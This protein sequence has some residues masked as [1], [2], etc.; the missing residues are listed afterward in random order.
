MIV[1]QQVSFDGGEWSPKLDC[2]ADL[3]KYGAACRLV[4]NFIPL[5]QG[6]LV[7]RPGMTLRGSMPGN[8]ADGRL[9]EFELRAANS[10][11]IAIGDNMMIF[12]KDG[13]PITDGGIVVTLGC[14]WNDGTLKLLRW[15]QI[16]D[17]MMFV[18]PDH[19][20]KILTRV[21]DTN[22]TLE[23][24][25]PARNHAFL[26]ENLDRTIRITSTFKVNADFTTWATGQAYKVGDRVKRSNVYYLCEQDHTSSSS[27]EPE[28]KPTYFDSEEEEYRLLWTREYVDTSSTKGQTVTLTCNKA[29]WTAAHVGS[30][31]ELA[32]KR[33]LWQFEARLPVDKTATGSNQVYSKALVV[34]GRWTMQTFGNWNGKFHV[35]ISRDRGMSWK[36]LRAV[37]ST[38]KTPRNASF[39]GE[40]PK[41]ALI[42]LMFT[43]YSANGTSGSPYAML[44]VEGAYLRGIVKITEF[45]NSK[46]VKAVTI[47]PIEKDTTDVWSEGA[48]S[49]HQGHPRCI[50]FHQGRVVLAATSKSPHTIWAS[51]DD[52]Y[53]NFRR[54][55]LA[56]DP[57]THTVMIGQREPIAWLLSDRALVI[58]SSVGEFV[59]IGA[60]SDKPITAEDR[61]VMRH[62]SIGSHV[63]G[64]GVLP[65]DNAA[66]YIQ[67]GGRL[68]REMGYRYESDRYEAANLTL[69]AD[70]LFKGNEITD[71]AL[72][73]APVTIVWFVAGG[74]LHS[75][76]YE[77]SQNVA[78]WARHPT[79]GTVV[80]V[81]CI[82][83]PAEDEVWFVVQHGTEWTVERFATGL[84][85]EPADA[86]QW[87]DCCQT[88]ASPY[89]L[90]GNPLQGLTVV[91]IH[92]GAI[93][94]P[95]TLNSGFFT[96]LTGNVT[97]GRP[98]S[99][100]V[101]PMTPVLQLKNGTSRTREIRIHEAVLSLYQSRGGKIGED[102]AGTKFDP[103]RAD[104]GTMFT[105][106][107][108]VS[109]DGRHG[110]AGAFCVVSDE[111]RPFFL[112]S[113]ILK[114]NVYGDA[115]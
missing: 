13:A 21:S 25:V 67:K 31:W 36:S 97:L 93:I 23:N 6:G 46:S 33:G 32:H 29:L 26:P 77:R 37:Q 49:D 111:P 100:K 78:A 61:N 95:A 89:N 58:G 14:P 103:V 112:R 60:D 65:A 106:E 87:S 47:T 91:G 27:N 9:V 108:A 54:G 99:A 73:R 50:E 105:G 84:M 3:E 75:L 72:Q 81:A 109:F 76:T 83:K 113:L 70:H 59:M 5:P 57:W 34:Q 68:V 45:T 48:W 71:F 114:F 115:G 56:T 17:V 30:V 104:S 94:G 19:P 11:V 24:F 66:L 22:W 86:G 82:R 102:P 15:K 40:E 69:L 42:R 1:S 2:R 107:K 63:N 85:S 44:N 98:Y 90:A 10:I 92:N 101:M 88:L 35:Q 110:T 79:A 53:N 4:E 96:G 41:R 38:A 12:F 52:D 7:K 18:H 64:P 43:D 39:E 74:V 8:P 55:T 16:N 80:S 28:D 20:P 51:A 62:S